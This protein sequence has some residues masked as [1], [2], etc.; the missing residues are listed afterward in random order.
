MA[1]RTECEASER[2][3]DPGTERVRGLA[4]LGGLDRCSGRV[5][6]QQQDAHGG[7]WFAD[8]DDA[9]A[10]TAERVGSCSGQRRLGGQSV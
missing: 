7:G 2:E 4:D 10:Q 1:D 8:G 3:P 5:R 9:R 6:V